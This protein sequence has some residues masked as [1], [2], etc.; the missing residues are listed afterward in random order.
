MIKDFLSLNEIQINPESV[1][2]HDEKSSWGFI[3]IQSNVHIKDFFT[4][5]YFVVLFLLFYIILA[6]SKDSIDLEA[7]ER[8]EWS[9]F[10]NFLT[11]ILNISSLFSPFQGI[12][13][14]IK[15]EG[16][17]HIEDFIIFT[18]LRNPFPIITQYPWI[19]L[20]V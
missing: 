9:V 1:M 4:F 12:F 14:L 6:V 19:I 5:P 10:Q 15:I 7:I 8:Y 3:N 11:C 18:L 20:I 2:Q 13:P 16:H 17:M